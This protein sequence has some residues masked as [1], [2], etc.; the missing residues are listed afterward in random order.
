MNSILLKI[1][2]FLGSPLFF[3]TVIGLFVFQALWLVSSALYPMAFDEAYHFSFIQVYS[4]QWSPFITEH[5]SYA[6][7]LG[8]VTRDTS[9]FFHYLMSFPYRLIT[10]FT[11][12]QIA[13]III[14]RII[15]VGFFAASL[16]LFRRAFRQL[17]LSS[18]LTNVGL[19]LFTLIPITPLLAA[20]ISYD[21][22][23][24]LLIS[25]LFY[26]SIKVI[27]RLQNSELDLLS[28]LGVIILIAFAG[29]VKQAA[30]PIGL[31]A[32][33]F[34]ASYG[35]YA[36]RGQ[37][38][39]GFSQEIGLRWR[40]I[41]SLL[42]VPLIVLLILGSGLFIERYGINLIRYGATAPGC[43]EVLTFEQCMETGPFERTYQYAQNPVPGF[44]PS[45]SDH[46]SRWI[47]GMWYRTFFMINGDVPIDRYHNFPPLPLPALGATAIFIAGIVAAIIYAK[48][49]F[50]RPEMVFLALA[51]LFYATV[52]WYLN[53]TG[54]YNYTGRV[55]GAN[56]RY[57]L[58]V[59]LPLIA[60]L[61]A[62][63]T[64]LLQRFDRL[65]VVAVVVVS[66]AMMNGG[67]VMSFWYRSSDTWYWDNPLVESMNQSAQRVVSPF[68]V[69]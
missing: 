65:K 45:F 9:Y 48:Q 69:E 1:K 22:L 44:S 46:S 17:N 30:L 55:A 60:V 15:N 63:L 52:I 7:H 28:L 31:T 19:L 67:G 14:L 49:I 50:R 8:V 3:W 20:H 64:K 51:A 35:G 26:L 29:V 57:L 32:V 12:N 38:L 13:Q 27:Q 25:A 10:V 18:A 59:A 6:N 4:Q 66:L 62:A 42:R 43:E 47:G 39:S 54:S 56:G 40:G 33:L 68:I 24:I 58:I 37:S 61:G 23:L 36:F 41:S 21:N 16:L 34:I 53:Y 2:Q 11:D 5:P